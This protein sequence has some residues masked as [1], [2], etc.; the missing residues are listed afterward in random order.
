MLFSSHILS[1]AEAVCSR[2]ALVSK[3]RLVASGRIAD[4]GLKVRSWELVVAGIEPSRV[5]TLAP[6]VKSVAR[7]ADG[8]YVIEFPVDRPPEHIAKELAGSGAQIIS[9]NPHHETLEEFFVAQ[10]TQP[11][12]DQRASA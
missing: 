9:L 4:L 6:T 3:G 1:D 5:D 2:V 11:E 10:V 7:V 8:R 12:K